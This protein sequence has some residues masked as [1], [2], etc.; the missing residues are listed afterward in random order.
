MVGAGLHAQHTCRAHG[1]Q[2]FRSFHVEPWLHRPRR[3]VVRPRTCKLT[4]SP[5]NQSGTLTPVPC[6][7]TGNA[8]SSPRIAWGGCVQIWPRHRG[9]FGVSS[10]CR[11]GLHFVVSIF[12]KVSDLLRGG[13]GG[14]RCP[15]R[16]G[17]GKFQ[18]GPCVF[19]LFEG[20]VGPGFR[21]WH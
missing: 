18:F 15:S 11:V 20:V 5:P 6:Q 21:L 7:N 12:G 4:D 13:D 2:R 14:R 3:L 8:P 16:S 1:S 19:C 17:R 9:N 10:R